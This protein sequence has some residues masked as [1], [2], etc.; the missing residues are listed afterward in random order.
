VVQRIGRVG[1]G[2][3]RFFSAIENVVGAE[4]NETRILFRAKSGERLRAESV[5]RPREVALDFAAI[6]EVVGGG[7]DDHVRPQPRQPLAHQIR[8]GQI[9]FRVAEENE[10]FRAPRH[11]GFPQAVRQQTVSAADKNFHL[12][13]MLGSACN[14]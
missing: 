4:V 5:D 12:G 10:I 11:G 13:F 3:G 14:P 2:V 1:L 8:P 6:H 7:V 9:K